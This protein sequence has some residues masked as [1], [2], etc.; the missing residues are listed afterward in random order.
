MIQEIVL[1][2][3]REI[4]KVGSNEW[5]EDSASV[6]ENVCL[7]LEDYFRDY[8]YLKPENTCS[9]KVQLQNRLA[10]SYIQAILNK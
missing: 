6:V 7:T 2:V 5:L 3:D 10:R 1:D 4:N 8:T 9:L